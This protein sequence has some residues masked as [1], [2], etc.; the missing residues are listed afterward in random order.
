[1]STFYV[2]CMWIATGTV[3]VEAANAQ[4]AAELA[5]AEGRMPEQHE[6]LKDSYRV[7]DVNTAQ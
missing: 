7:M 5:R 1:M 4:D 6:I 2:D 3:I